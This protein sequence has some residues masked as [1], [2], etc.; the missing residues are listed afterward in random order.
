MHAMSS[1]ASSEKNQAVLYTGMPGMLRSSLVELQPSTL[2]A[3]RSLT[4]SPVSS[5]TLSSP[6]CRALNP[7][8]HELHSC[9]SQS[10]HTVTKTCS[11]SL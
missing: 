7:G 3:T 5:Q 11:E 8:L 10:L 4:C 6:L 1:C 2:Q 9:Y